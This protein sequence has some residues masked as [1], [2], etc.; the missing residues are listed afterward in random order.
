V[1][2]DIGARSTLAFALMARA[3]LLAAERQG[4][5]SEACRARAVRIADEVGLS[6]WLGADGA[7]T[8]QSM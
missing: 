1:A 2:E 4:A 8:R 3:D 5:E 6:L 7:E